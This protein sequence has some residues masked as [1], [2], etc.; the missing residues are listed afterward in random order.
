M[1][2]QATPIHIISIDYLQKLHVDGIPTGAHVTRAEEA[3]LRAILGHSHCA[4]KDFILT[5]V[6]GGRDEPEI[7]IIDVFVTRL[8]AKL[9][10][11]R[12]A[13]ITVWGRG[14]AR[15]PNYRIEP[16]DTPLVAVGVDAKLIE[17]VAFASD[18]PIDAIVSRLLTAERNRLWSPDETE[19]A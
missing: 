11:H 15:H 19:A 13:I 3:I 4:T 12:D 14:Y 16:K 5:A 10:Q 18:E 9:G 2:D 6:Y 8:R 17:D 7:K 1:S